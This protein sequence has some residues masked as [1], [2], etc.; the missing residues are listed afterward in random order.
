MIVEFLEYTITPCSA[1]ARSMGF[2]KS[3]IEV[4]AR[5]RRCRSAWQAHL[6]RTRES[7][8]EAAKLSKGGV[9]QS[10]SGLASSTIFHCANYP[11]CLKKLY[12][13]TSSTPFRAV[14][15]PRLSETSH[16]YQRM[17]QKRSTNYRN[18]LVQAASFR[19]TCLSSSCSMT[20]WTSPYP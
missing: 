13:W 9:R 1:I 20:E 18:W 17:S 2:L 3:S 10:Y 11:E 19:A 5:Y 7:I 8:L 4:R 6:D 12:W 14:C 16:G 15:R